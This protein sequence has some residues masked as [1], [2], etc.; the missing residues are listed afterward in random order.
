MILIIYTRIISFIH[1]RESHTHTTHSGTKLF[2]YLESILKPGD[3]NKYE[4]PLFD[5]CESVR[6]VFCDLG[7]PKIVRR[8]SDCCRWRN[9]CCEDGKVVAI[10]FLTSTDR[11]NSGTI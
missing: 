1:F 10:S 5:E 2:D 11:W 6:Q 3:I 8:G 9:T 7:V 4:K